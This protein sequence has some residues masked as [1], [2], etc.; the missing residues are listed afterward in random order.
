LVNLLEILKKKYF[1]KK[2]SNMFHFLY[3]SSQAEVEMYTTNFISILIH[4]GIIAMLLSIIFAFINYIFSFFIYFLKSDANKS[5]YECGFEPFDES[6]RHPFD[7]HFYI[8]GILF[9][10]FDLEISCLVPAVFNVGNNSYETVFI[11][12]LFLSIVTLGFILE[13]NI[14]ALD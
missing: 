6:M 5:A 13:Y 4:M 8:V 12:A 2:C 7:I 11:I 10:V 3:L 14:G 9:L 1:G